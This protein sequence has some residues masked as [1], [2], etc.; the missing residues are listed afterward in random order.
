MKYNSLDVF[1]WR[2]GPVV[3]VIRRRA[4][5][6]ELKRQMERGNYL[7]STPTLD[8]S[9]SLYLKYSTK[10][11]SFFLYILNFLLNM[12]FYYYFE[13]FMYFDHFHTFP[14]L[15]SS[16]FPSLPIQICVLFFKPWDT[17][18][19]SK[20]ILDVRSSSATW[21]IFCILL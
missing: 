15:P 2:W 6:S 20:I 11:I 18:C 14:N 8:T 12:K 13:D 16:V 1:W 19:A 5:F 3:P 17:I 4:F 9:Y 10:C 21:S 7:L